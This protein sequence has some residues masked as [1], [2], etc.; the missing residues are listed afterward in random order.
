MSYP[1]SRYG[2]AGDEVS[3]IYRPGHRGPD[4]EIGS[5]VGLSHLAIRNESAEPASMLILFSPG[6]PREGYFEAIAERV[7]G[8]PYTEEEWTELCER[9]DNYFV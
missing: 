8:R 1:E 3:A 4:L 9:H 6:A 5:A 2:G 7:A